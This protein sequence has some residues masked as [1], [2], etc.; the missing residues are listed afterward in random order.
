MNH[1]SLATPS[2]A[3]TLVHRLARGLQVTG[4]V[5]LSLRHSVRQRPAMQLLLAE[6][7]R[8]EATDPARSSALRKAAAR[9]VD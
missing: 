5:L 8:W 2:W 4:S 1:A 6:A 3:D 9:L 7:N